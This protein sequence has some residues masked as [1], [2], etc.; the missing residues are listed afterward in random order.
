MKL[1]F[2]SPLSPQRSGISDYSETLLPF[3]AKGA[4]IDLFTEK[5]VPPTNSQIVENFEVCPY[6]D[7]AQRHQ[8]SPYDLCL[9]QMGN[10]PK[11]HGYM[12]ELIHRYP[13]IVTIHDFALQHYYI[14]IFLKDFIPERCAEYVAS[15]KRYYGDLGEK[16]AKRFTFER[17]HE[18][19][20]YQFPMWQR[21]V[22]PSLGTIV[23]SSYVKMKMLQYDASYQ[24]EMIPMGIFPPKLEDYPMKSL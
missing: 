13:G 9:Y 15:M 6:T 12:D 11:F 1:A 2:F 8:R 7:F 19:P 3:L 4:H 18:Y 16:V 24:V 10:N 20:F 5:D 14:T 21:V 22:E 17:L 23:H